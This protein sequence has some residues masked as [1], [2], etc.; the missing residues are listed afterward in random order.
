MNL[1]QFFM[2]SYITQKR[3]KQEKSH[4]R[5]K[6]GSDIVL[7]ADLIALY[8]R[9]RWILTW[10]KKVVPEAL[11]VEILSRPVTKVTFHGQIGD[12]LPRHSMRISSRDD[13]MNLAL[14]IPEV[15]EKAKLYS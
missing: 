10:V 14:F 11:L 2:S 6:G 8:S 9:N 3:K 5:S 4:V 7:E 1:Q 12:M 13:I 15:Y